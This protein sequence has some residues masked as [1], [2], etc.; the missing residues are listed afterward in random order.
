MYGYYLYPVLLLLE[1]VQEV[2]LAPT[3]TCTVH[4]LKIE[5]LM[6]RYFGNICEKT[7]VEAKCVA[8]WQLLYLLEMYLSDGERSSGSGLANGYGFSNIYT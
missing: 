6:Y 5:T 8:S 4:T 7:L 2:V 1:V 3:I